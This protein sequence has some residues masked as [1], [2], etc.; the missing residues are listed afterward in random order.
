[1]HVFNNF[2]YDTFSENEAV[3]KQC[4]R[5]LLEAGVD[6]TIGI[7]TFSSPLDRILWEGS[8]VMRNIKS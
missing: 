1:M 4:W 6:P 2:Q 7:R 5:Y 3:E 8:K